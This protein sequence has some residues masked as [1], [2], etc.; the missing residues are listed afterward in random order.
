MDLRHTKIL[1]DCGLSFEPSE[2]QHHK[3]TSCTQRRM[4]CMWCHLPTPQSDLES[5][6]AYCGGKTISCNLCQQSI[7]RKRMQIHLAVQHNINPSL[8]KNVRHVTA[9]YH[10]EHSAAPFTASTSDLSRDD[11]LAAAI[12]E[13]K[14]LAGHN[15]DDDDAALEAALLASQTN[16]TNNIP[17]HLRQESEATSTT[18][19]FSNVEHDADID[20]WDEDVMEDENHNAAWHSQTPTVSP[21]AH[22][23][24]NAAN[25]IVTPSNQ[26]QQQ[27]QPPTSNTTATAA[28]QEDNAS[29]S[30]S[31]P[32][33]D[34]QTCPYCFQQTASFDAL[35]QH[36]EACELVE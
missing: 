32:P 36:L 1:C 25:P 35:V 24:A 8:K 27:P 5:H 22:S 21:H 23:N 19:D 16:T 2:L 15:H 12:A 29:M 7:A 4:N 33:V 20:D 31:P 10:D 9:A 34:L 28:Q 26:Q 3:E 14:R 6:Q 18:D 13:S 17:R 11:E 30:V